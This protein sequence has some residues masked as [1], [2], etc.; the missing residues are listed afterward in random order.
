MVSVVSVAAAVVAVVMKSAKEHIHLYVVEKAKSILVN[1]GHSI[2]E[3]TYDLGFDYPQNFSKLFK[4]K[5]GLSPSEY[6]KWN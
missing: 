4:T 6:G 1:T 3:I 5:M 2:S